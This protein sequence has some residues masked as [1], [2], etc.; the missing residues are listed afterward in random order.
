MS[1]TE[2]RKMRTSDPNPKSMI[3][4]LDEPKTIEKKIKSA[5]TDSEGIVKFDKENKPGISNLLTICSSFSGK[6]VEEIESNVRR[7]RI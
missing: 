6:T 1:L 4:M 2:L 7:K 5:V 3:S